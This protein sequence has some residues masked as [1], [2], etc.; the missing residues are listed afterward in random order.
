MAVQRDNPY[1]VFNFLVD[2]DDGDPGSVIGGFQEVDG[3]STDINIAEYR[4]GNEKT[5][6]VRK[7]PGMYSVG[8][9]TLRRGLIGALNLWQWLLAVRNGDQNAPRDI[10][11]QLLDES[12]EN[13]VM[14]WRLSG[15]IPSSYSAPSLNAASSGDVAIEE[16]VLACE[17]IAVE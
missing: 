3:L 12:Q 11:I 1:G 17:D 16:L 4:N 6:H 14:T 10:S 5:N 15:A 13:V 7:I 8:D 9:V 2:L